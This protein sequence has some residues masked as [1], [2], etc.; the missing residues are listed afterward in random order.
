M[1]W[2]GG[3]MCRSII[4]LRG[5]DAVSDDDVHAAALQYVRKVSGY[6]APSQA[7]RAVFERA[8]EDVARSTQTLLD[9]LVSGPGAP[10]PTTA[11]E[12][13]RP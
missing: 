4:T 13:A 5:L 7:N 1:V 6:R 3:G 8:V 9:E 10:R 2:H 11:R 12:A